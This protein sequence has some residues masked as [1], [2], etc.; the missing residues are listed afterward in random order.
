[1]KNS[2]STTNPFKK[3]KESSDQEVPKTEN[4]Q[5]FF[6]KKSDDTTIEISHEPILSSSGGHKKES[7]LSFLSLH[8]TLP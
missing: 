8:P 7:L 2:S 5:F 3:F 1:M 6:Q 4:Y